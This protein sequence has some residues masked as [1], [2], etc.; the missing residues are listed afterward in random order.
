MEEKKFTEKE[1]RAAY[2]AY[3]KAARAKIDRLINELDNLKTQAGNIGEEL[4]TLE[5][6]IKA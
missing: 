4:R 5:A 3:L 2:E 6:E 1:E